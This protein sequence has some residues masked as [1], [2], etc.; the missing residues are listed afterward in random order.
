MIIGTISRIR[1]KARY[2]CKH[3]LDPLFAVLEYEATYLTEEAAPF[4]CDACKRTVTGLPTRATAE[5]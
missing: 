1:G 5:R 2:L 3:C 4:Q